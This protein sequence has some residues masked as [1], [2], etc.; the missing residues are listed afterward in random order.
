MKK[1]TAITILGSLILLSG[2]YESPTYPE[3]QG[4][5]GILQQGWEAYGDNDFS[6]ALGYFQ[7]CIDADPSRSE[8]YMGAGWA[9]IHLPDYWRIADRYFYMALQQETGLYP[10]DFC[11]E[12]QVQDTMWTVFE[13]LHPDLPES[14]LDPILEATADS[15]MMWVG[16]TIASL[17]NGGPIPYR[18]KPLSEDE[19]LSISR[20][21]NGFTNDT[22]EVDSIAT[23]GWVYLTV[24]MTKVRTVDGSYYTW[25][26]VDQKVEYSLGTLKRPDGLNSQVVFDALVGSVML[27][28]ARGVKSGDPLMAIASAM[29][30]DKLDSGYA[31]GSGNVNQG[32]EDIN[33]LNVKGMAAA[34]AFA[35][36]H[37]KYTLFLC[38]TSGRGQDIDPGSPT[39]L[40]D[41]MTLI[42]AMIND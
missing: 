20:L 2:C 5:N 42:E 34:Q 1:I 21:V 25:I 26:G 41:L 9:M 29:L 15:G 3:V 4:Y 19:L 27:Q 35:S 14:V 8:G 6:A 10:M 38:R 23:D 16:D 40:T 22:L 37:F 30:L 18:F 24:P 39:F 32:L 17:V 13:C 31:F 28:D 7:D 36:R 11:F 12:V 33:N